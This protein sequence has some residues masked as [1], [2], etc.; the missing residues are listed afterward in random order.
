MKLGIFRK[1]EKSEDAPPT[2]TPLGGI[3]SSYAHSLTGQRSKFKEA[4]LNVTHTE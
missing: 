2:P 3:S 1:Q 4:D